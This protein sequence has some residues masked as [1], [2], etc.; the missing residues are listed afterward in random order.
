M[1]E[2]KPFWN[3]RKRRPCCTGVCVIIITR[4]SKRIVTVSMIYGVPQLR[5]CCLFF[6]VVPLSRFRLRARPDDVSVRRVFQRVHVTCALWGGDERKVGFRC[7]TR[8]RFSILT[9]SFFT[10]PPKTEFVET[11]MSQSFFFFFVLC[12]YTFYTLLYRDDNNKNVAW[13]TRLMIREAHAAKRFRKHFQVKTKP[14][15]F[16]NGIFK[17]GIFDDFELYY[18]L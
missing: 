3:C 4:R 14:K 1:Y 10:C 2:K 9:F 6:V 17:N 18:W 11:R 15:R 16:G 7:V 12:A 13:R 5:C 8:L